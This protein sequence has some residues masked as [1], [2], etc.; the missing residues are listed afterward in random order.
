MGKCSKYVGSTSITPPRTKRSLKTYVIVMPS[1]DFQ[2]KAL[3]E[4][5]THLL[6]GEFFD[7]R[8]DSRDDGYNC[9]RRQ[10]KTR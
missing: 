1:S 8:V 4:R 3:D 5:I 2:V 10:R 7:Q 6:R 9:P